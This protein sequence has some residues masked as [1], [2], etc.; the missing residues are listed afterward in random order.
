GG[1]TEVA[2]WHNRALV[3]SAVLPYGGDHLTH[4]IATSL[5][6]PRK[7]AERIKILHGCA[8]SS[9]VDDDEKINVACV[10]G[11]TP[12][13]RP[14]TLLCDIIEP[15]LEEVFRLV[16]REVQVS[17]FADLVGGFVVTGG[18]ALMQGITELGE[19]VLNQPVRVGKPHPNAKGVI[20]VGNGTGMTGGLSGLYDIVKAPSYSTAVGLLQLG[21]AEEPSQPKRGWWS[22]TWIERL[23][24]YMSN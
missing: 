23:K 6:T 16:E 8:L 19:D 12:T 24:G 18:T 13:E 14:R 9:L 20:G 7:E 17:N 15:R 2:V 5:R 1:T 10:G 11:R 4:D 21:A 22:I 3:H